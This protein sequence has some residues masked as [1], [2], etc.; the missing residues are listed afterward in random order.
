[1]FLLCL[2]ASLVYAFL[3]IVAIVFD[4]AQL[5]S[6]RM[7]ASVVLSGFLAPTI[8][9]W[10]A[11]E[12]LN[13]LSPRRLLSRK[14]SMPVRRLT[15]GAIAGIL[16]S[17]LGVLGM[18]LLDKYAVPDAALT[19]AAAMFTTVAVIL[20]TARIRRGECLYCRYSLAG[21]TPASKGVCAECG[22]DAMAC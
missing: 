19:G 20:P 7:M 12:A 18:A 4:H 6:G 15:F 3:A 13:L 21:A 9:T 11:A 16:A 22:A 2:A 5:E 17:V 14:L 1:M 10:L 8:A